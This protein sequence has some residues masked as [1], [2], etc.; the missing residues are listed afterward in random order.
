[1]AQS[2]VDITSDTYW[3]PDDSSGTA[4]YVYTGGEW[5]SSEDESPFVDT[6]N[7]TLDWI[8]SSGYSSGLSQAFS[9]IRF[10]VRVN[11]ATTNQGRYTV[12]IDTAPGD[13]TGN[14]PVS[15]TATIEV[16]LSAD[17]NEPVSIT[18]HN[19]NSFDGDYAYYDIT[20]IEVYADDG[21]PDEFW[22]DEATPHYSENLGG[23]A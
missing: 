12:S 9:K 14:L 22:D 4:D 18:L 19:D 3:E 1:M 6:R 11:N 20:S 16:D 23:S 17:Y 2:W 5:L 13:F 21:V 15:G 10:G 7:D 8:Y